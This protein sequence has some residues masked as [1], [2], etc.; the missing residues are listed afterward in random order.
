MV[1]SAARKRR[2]A[3]EAP[4]NARWREESRSFRA[5]IRAARGAPMPRWGDAR[6]CRPAVVKEP[7]FEGLE[8]GEQVGSWRMVVEFSLVAR[9]T[10]FLGAIYRPL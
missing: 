9:R 8:G 2:V 6:R 7:F 5:A 3:P 1:G 4:L 10:A